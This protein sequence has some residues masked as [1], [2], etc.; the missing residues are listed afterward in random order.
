[1][2]IGVNIDVSDF[3]DDYYSFKECVKEELENE[4]KKAIKKDIRWKQFVNK[5]VDSFFEEK[6]IAHKGKF[7]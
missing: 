1:M 5:N 3:E 2:K 4:I 6:E 7:K